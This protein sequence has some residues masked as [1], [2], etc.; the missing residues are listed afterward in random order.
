MHRAN[1]EGMTNGLLDAVRVLVL[2]Q[3]GIL[4]TSTI[5]SAL[6]SAVFGLSPTVWLSALS[7][8]LALTAAAGLV[9]KARWARKVTLL[10]EGYLLVTLLI[11]TAISLLMTQT[12]LGLV[13]LLTRGV[14]PVVVWKLLRRPAV[15]AEFRSEP[16][17]QL[18]AEAL[19][20]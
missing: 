2:I 17:A 9:R 14:V 20:P 7:A 19:T 1:H 15:A 11:D 16:S 18:V 12:P 8:I 10:G 13:P 5:E 4:L 6:A 3:G